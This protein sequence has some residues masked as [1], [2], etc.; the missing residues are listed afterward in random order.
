MKPMTSHHKAGQWATLSLIAIGSAHLAFATPE[1]APSGD[2]EAAEFIQMDLNADSRL[3]GSEMNVSI[4]GGIAIITGSA[5]SIAQTERA[6]ARA[7]ANEGVLAVSNQAV[8]KP[9]NGT[10]LVAK[11]KAALAKQKT[12][13][14]DGV[15]V[16]ANG[17]RISLIGKVGTPDERDLAREIVSEV[18]GVLAIDNNLTVTY[19]GIREDS[20]ITEQLHFIIQDDP[21]YEGLHLVALVKDG[22]ATL[23][24]EVGSRGELDRLVRRSYV[25]GVTDV[26]ISGLTINSN[27]KMEGLEDKDYTQEQSL[28]ALSHALAADPRIHAENIRSTMTDGI[29]TLQGNVAQIAESD[30][31]ESTARGI[32]G[33]LS[34]TNELKAS[35]G[36]E[37]ATA[38]N[39]T[40]SVSVPVMQASR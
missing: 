40:K 30:A 13:T 2:S 10:D 27:L 7:I 19:E 28:E 26:K 24:G 22:T 18:P 17:P 5:K 14:A 4:K 25:T 15:T 23:K 32:P 12:F 11:A 16:T 38:K 37:V 21:L 35:G 9:G 29:V 8:I 6:T 33:V 39:E 3:R 34:V 36:T 31:A 20:Q 1:A